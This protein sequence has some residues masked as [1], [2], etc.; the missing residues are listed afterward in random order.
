M[1]AYQPTNII[2]LRYA[3]QMQLYFFPLQTTTF[4]QRRDAGTR[5]ENIGKGMYSWMN[6]KGDLW[7]RISSIIKRQDTITKP[8]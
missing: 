8:G 1:G 3:E 2:A 5:W 7:M 6:R 4:N